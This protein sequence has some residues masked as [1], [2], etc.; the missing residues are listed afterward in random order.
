MPDGRPGRLPDFLVIG[1]MK[2]GTSSLHRY[3]RA[4]PG[5]FMPE[6]K[7]LNF[8]VSDYRGPVPLDPPEVTN[9]ARGE[10][11]YR[12]WF[13]AAGPTQLAGEA[14]PKYTK[15][16]EYP[17]APERIAA[18][19]PDARLVYVVRD[20]IE[21]IRSHYLHDV[22]VGRERGTID[23]AVRTDPRYV[24]TS[25]YTSQLAG[26]LAHF[27]AG[28][29]LVVLS[30]ELLHDRAATLARVLEHIGADPSA[31]PPQLDI[32]AHASAGKRQPS[33]TAVR[34]GRIP[35]RRLVP[36]AFRD[37]VRGAVTRPI[38]PAQAAIDDRLRD[39]LLV[40]LE[41][42]IEGMREL[43]GPR[44]DVWPSAARLA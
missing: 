3:L 24:S 4:H 44:L 25:R 21:R 35:G 13:D 16:P 36:R 12:A 38:D 18:L 5:I 20:P 2:G 19:L 39:W 29:V 6:V 14:S 26:Y 11:W 37:A 32:D 7:E 43:L 15:A 28:Q 8:F 31:I 41:A 22:A 42:E 1:T 34:L 17:G 9:W 23:N 27:P 10:D 40:Q 30:E 33:R